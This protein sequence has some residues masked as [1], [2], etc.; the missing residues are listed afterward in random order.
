MEKIN[1]TISETVLSIIT[2]DACVYFPAENSKSGRPNINGL[3]NRIIPSLLDVR[4][5]R[6]AKIAIW[7][8]YRKKNVEGD[9]KPFK[10]KSY[11]FHT[12]TAI[13]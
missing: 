1:V 7:D 12:D 2:N 13:Y 8:Y 3:L 5:E 11:V 6:R 4:K 10:K 9:S